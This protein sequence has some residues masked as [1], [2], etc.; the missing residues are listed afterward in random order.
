M[1]GLPGL[2]LLPD[3]P[4]PGRS[5]RTH[6]PRRQTQPEAGQGTR[7]HLAAFHTGYESDRGAKPSAAK[8][9]QDQR[10]LPKRGGSEETDLPIHHQRHPEMDASRRLD[11]SPAGIQDPLRRPST[12]LTP[13]H[14]G[15][16]PPTASR[17]GNRAVR[18]VAP[19][20]AI[21]ANQRP[22][23][24]PRRDR[25]RPFTPMSECGG[26]GARPKRAARRSQ[27]QCS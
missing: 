7:Q 22:L 25:G 1:N 6:Q 12:R 16:R 27:R 3:A 18:D 8:S 17:Q 10:T 14:L 26:G 15:G 13:T 9:D 4:H 19:C 11:E 21:V 20:K 23:A 2:R 5:H 24:G